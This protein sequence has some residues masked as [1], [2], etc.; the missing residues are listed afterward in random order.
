MVRPTQ[1]RIHKHRWLLAAMT[2]NMLARP[3]P[4]YLTGVRAHNGVAGNLHIEYAADSLTGNAHLDPAVLATILM[5][6]QDCWVQSSNRA[7]FFLI[8]LIFLRCDLK[9]ASASLCVFRRFRDNRPEC[10]KCKT[11][12]RVQ[13][14]CCH[15]S[16]LHVASSAAFC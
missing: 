7:S 13:A 12:Q 4:V 10:K 8:W 11:F 15:G 6:P 2:Q 9:V 16:G 3:A 5:D 1:L 14:A